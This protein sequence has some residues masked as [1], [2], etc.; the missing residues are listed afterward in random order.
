MDNRL[1]TTQRE[2]LR[3]KYGLF[4]SIIKDDF[5]TYEQYKAERTEVYEELKAMIVEYGLS[6]SEINNIQELIYSENQL[7]FIEDAKDAKG[8]I[9]FDYSGRGMYG[10]CCPALYCESHND[11]TT[12]AKTKIDSMGSD[13]VIY[14][15]D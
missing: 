5:D 7:L 6:E 10:D 3:R 9:H 4:K 13:I 2:N 14:A 8:T 12:K 1:T 15:Q 11:I